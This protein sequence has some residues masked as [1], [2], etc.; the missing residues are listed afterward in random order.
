M[1]GSMYSLATALH[2]ETAS[3][4]NIG[5]KLIRSQRSVRVPV[6][7]HRRPV[8]MELRK[9]GDNGPH[10]ISK[11]LARSLPVAPLED[12]LKGTLSDLGHG[13]PAA[14]MHSGRLSTAPSPT[15]A[16]Q[17]PPT[18]NVRVI[19]VGGRG[20]NIVEHVKSFT[21]GAGD[22]LEL[23]C[24]DTDAQALGNCK[25]PNQL[26]LAFPAA[27]KGSAPGSGNGNGG[28]NGG[29]GNGRPSGLEA[30]EV[31]RDL[32]AAATNG[33]NALIVAAGTGGLTGGGAAPVIAELAARDGQL[34]AA[35]V[36]APFRF[37]GTRR[38]EQAYSS[39]AALSRTVDC[40]VVIDQDLLVDEAAS[41][42]LA[43]AT[44]AANDAMAHGVACLGAVLSGSCDEMVVLRGAPAG[45]GQVAQAERI[46]P[47]DVH[48]M[49]ENSGAA[50]M[51]HAD[52]PDGMLQ[53]G[54]G[55]GPPPGPG[56]AAGVSSA[57]DHVMGQVEAAV[58][59]AMCSP[60]LAGM[61]TA[62]K[63]AIC[64]LSLPPGVAHSFP[65]GAPALSQHGARVLQHLM[66][67]ERGI[68]LETAHPAAGTLG[69]D[70]QGDNMGTLPPIISGVSQKQGGGRQHSNISCTILAV[71]CQH[72]SQPGSPKIWPAG[73]AAP[74]AL[75]AASP[76]TS[77]NSP[78][79]T[80]PPRNNG[81]EYVTTAASSNNG[82]SLPP[83]SPAQPSDANGTRGPAPFPGPP[84][85]A[86]N[87]ST[88]VASAGNGGMGGTPQGAP[89]SSQ[90]GVPA[91]PRMGGG[92]APSSRP[93]RFVDVQL[94]PA[95]QLAA[96]QGAFAAQKKGMVASGP[97]GG[98]AAAP[99]GS[100]GFPPNSMAA[101]QP[102]GD[103][104]PG[105][106]R[107]S[108]PAA[109]SGAISQGRADVNATVSTSP[110]TWGAPTAAPSL[111][112]GN[113]GGGWGGSG[114]TQS[115]RGAAD[116]S[117]PAASTLGSSSVNGTVSAGSNSTASRAQGTA[118]TFTSSSSTVPRASPK[119]SSTS[120]SF[121][122]PS[123]PAAP[124]F[125]PSSPYASRL[126]ADLS[127]DAAASSGRD[128]WDREGAG[129]GRPE[130]S[131]G[132]RRDGGASGGRGF[133][134]GGFA[135]DEDEAEEMGDE[136]EE[137][138]GEDGGGGLASRF[139]R[140]V[141]G[142]TGSSKK[143]GR[144]K[145]P[146]R[147]ADSQRWRREAASGVVLR[148]SEDDTEGGFSSLQARTSELLGGWGA[149]CPEGQGRLSYPDGSWYDGHW[150][151]G[152]RD[153]QGT[154]LHMPTGTRY[155]GMWCDDFQEGKGLLT[156]SNGERLEGTFLGGLAH[157][158][159]IY[160]F[161]N[162]DVFRGQF[163]EGRRHG[164]GILFMA[165]GKR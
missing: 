110:P 78:R 37:E 19:G 17:S 52:C 66:A 163:R 146:S 40:L 126:A 108:A 93:P 2:M 102:S 75:S 151:N 41:V 59:A 62:S 136:I 142:L 121:T 128:P 97:P 3:S 118:S 99:A 32:I 141:G 87:W 50:T 154:F 27:G 46:S 9:G 60:F 91:D 132:P 161:E 107:W 143:G 101:A 111:S 157:G 144:G 73:L 123:R 149:A 26:H 54:W 125:S 81:R 20:C 22:Q 79:T 18:A 138:P 92:G 51:G 21:G 74:A 106:G 14:G 43:S 103:G 133:S 120:P 48:R 25:V 139:F 156:Y 61:L 24:M 47:R 130:G 71:G 89:A 29:N 94:S 10:K 38:L 13:P 153:G 28:G 30:A 55:A 15:R 67:I 135:D 96:Q 23:W 145:K 44:D 4:A 5:F 69:G 83:G 122:T 109:A 127:N 115:V 112:G 105:A 16:S 80:A 77:R 116:G 68:L 165:D 140:A 58:V 150:R 11:F 42:T 86:A 162:Q 76:A 119:K 90:G 6:H 160:R 113:P 53:E 114:A 152:K 39:I 1:L 129:A 49:L 88:H 35:V 147:G 65:G 57:E 34:T 45:A 85:G 158:T 148:S 104:A 82:A 63:A 131:V 33:S 7:G 164:E 84:G 8:V 56:R 95:E 98:S 12:S 72:T 70:L 64:L 159:C 137:L 134:R 36:A 31:S 155:T 124:S 117:V 100:P